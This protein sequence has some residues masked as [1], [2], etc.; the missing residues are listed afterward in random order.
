MNLEVFE[1][2]ETYEDAVK[3]A[4]QERQRR[5]NVYV[6]LKGEGVR[7]NV[8]HDMT[9]KEALS[10]S[11]QISVACND[12]YAITEKLARKLEMHMRLPFGFFDHPLPEREL[13]ASKVRAIRLL[14]KF[15]TYE[16]DRAWVKSSKTKLAQITAAPSGERGVSKNLYLQ[17]VA[18][19]R[20]KKPVNQA[21]A[22]DSDG[23]KVTTEEN[24]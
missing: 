5:F 8:F 3:A 15:K 1:G 2:A 13:R 10:L 12:R 20:A 21:V 16:L 19:L 18:A 7:L 24:V 9:D 6:D 11:N 4:Q 23:G 22:G 14:R 17:A